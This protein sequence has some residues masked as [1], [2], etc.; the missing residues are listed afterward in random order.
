MKKTS[1]ILSLIFSSFFVFGQNTWDGLKDDLKDSNED[2]VHHRKK[3]KSRTWL[4]RAEL[5]LEIHQFNT[6]GLS[7][8]M[9]A[10]GGIVNVKTVVGEPEKKLTKGDEQIWLYPHKKL[11]FK[12]GLLDHW[13]ETEFIEEEALQKAAYALK[14][15][16]SLEEKE[17]RTKPKFQEPAMRVRIFLVNKSIG[18]YQ[19]EN[20][21]EA[22]GFM[23]EAIQ[24]AH[25]PKIDNDTTYTLD[26]L[27]YYAGIIAIKSD[28]I[29]KA[30]GHFANCIRME[31]N[32]GSSYH[33]LAT[34]YGQSKDS[35]MYIK[36]V[37]EGFEKYPNEEQLVIDLINYYIKKN[38]PN[39]VIEYID[40]A[41]EKNP[42]NPSYYSAKATIY[43]NRDEDNFDM[44]KLYM[45]SVH[46]FKK[47]AF[48]HRFDDKK[49]FY[50]NKKKEAEKK[51]SEIKAEANKN[52][53]KAHKLYSKALDVDPKFFNAAFNRGRLYYKRHERKLWE[54]DIIFKIYRDAAKSDEPKKDVKPSL[55]SAAESFEQAHSIKPND[56]TTVDI[57]RSIYYKLRD[58]EK[59]EKY[60]D[61]L[62]KLKSESNT[63]EDIN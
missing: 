57:L 11:F 10:E 31:Y 33:Y 28:R 18:L 32:P 58:K 19:K 30:K 51:A 27:H 24:L 26:L 49:E 60:S 6:A 2:I 5:L 38:E 4:S 61:L 3:D 50:E 44:F 56:I 15:A 52:F 22:Y 39:K 29:E 20:F 13:E 37:K 17:L 47:K 59:K 9:A 40:F 55:L 7:E 1:L 46:Q 41:I 62:N 42:E 36:K 34:A 63:N 54:S 48:Q 8:G 21:E 43:D 12:N 45:D 35:A 23:E 25:Y 53:K 14:V 16:D